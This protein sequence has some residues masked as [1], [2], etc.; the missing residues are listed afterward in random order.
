MKMSSIC[1]FFYLIAKN[2]RFTRSQNVPNFGMKWS[3]S[4]RF[5]GLRPRPRWR[6]LRPFPRPPSREGLLAFVNRSFA[7]SELAIW[8]TRTFW[9]APQLLDLNFFPSRFPLLN[10]WIQPR[11]WGLWSWRLMD[12]SVYSVS[13]QFM[14]MFPTQFMFLSP[15]LFHE[16]CF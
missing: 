12:I 13:T 1:S 6:S 9:K 3:K 15:L 10:S 8:P 14:F 5:L 4:L 7:P 11:A 16:S 2:L